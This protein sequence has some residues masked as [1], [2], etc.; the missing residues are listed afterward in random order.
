MMKRMDGVHDFSWGYSYTEDGKHWKDFMFTTL[1]EARDFADDVL[2][3][4]EENKNFTGFPTRLC[5]V[6]I[7]DFYDR[8]YSPKRASPSTNPRKELREEPQMSYSVG[9]DG[10]KIKVDIPT[11]EAM[12][13]IHDADVTTC[14][15]EGTF[16]P[17]HFTPF[18]DIECTD[19]SIRASNYHDTALKVLEPY[20]TATN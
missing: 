15:L 10:L 18:A 16:K 4:N 14:R 20:I 19:G 9:T 2:S 13:I 6:P 5:P 12:R 3:K 11:N 8:S 7:C 1:D 17:G